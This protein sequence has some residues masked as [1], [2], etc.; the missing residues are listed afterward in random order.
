[1]AEPA[2]VEAS[3]EA[4]SAEPP[5]KKP[6]PARRQTG[7]APVGICRRR[8]PLDWPLKT[9]KPKHK[10]NAM[11]AGLESPWPAGRI[12]SPTSGGRRYSGAG[13]RLA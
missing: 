9:Q 5:G 8:R 12:S 10:L 13:H 11:A 2:E 6:P 4:A 3:G 7:G 1:M